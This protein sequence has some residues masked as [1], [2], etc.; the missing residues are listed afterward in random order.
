MLGLRSSRLAQH[1]F[2]LAAE[3]PQH[4]HQAFDGNIAELTACQSRYVRL[5]ETHA[6]TGFGS[7]EAMVGYDFGDA[8]DEPR[9]QEMGF[10]VGVAE[11]R[12]KIPASAPDGGFIGNN[13]LPLRRAKST[14]LA[15]FIPRRSGTFRLSAS[16]V[17]IS[18][19]CRRAA[20]Q[21]KARAVKTP[22]VSARLTRDIAKSSIGG[23]V[24]VSL[25]QLS[26]SSMNEPGSA[27]KSRNIL[28]WSVS[29]NRIGSR[30]DFPMRSNLAPG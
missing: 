22:V 20:S 3:T 2:D 29:S 15:I 18:I 9:L 30:P 23:T 10:R 17:L 19:F 12:E 21:P 7:G 5:A 6:F 11:I 13:G 4:S 24:P 25:F 27:Q 14:A 16:F 8:S 1:D 28:K 26:A